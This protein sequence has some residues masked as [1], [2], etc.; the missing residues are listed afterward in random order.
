MPA[1]SATPTTP[2]SSLSAPVT[3]TSLRAAPA[4]RAAAPVT[5]PSSAP[6]FDGSVAVANAPPAPSSRSIDM[7]AWRA[8][9]QVIRAENVPLAAVLEHASPIHCNPERLV[10]GYEP[11]SF[12]AVQAT[13]SAAVE[14]LTRHV[15]AHFGAP[16][17]VA[18]DIT[19]GPKSTPSVASLDNEER[20]KKLEQAKRAV[21]EHPLVRAAVEVLGAELADVRLPE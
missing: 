1:P 11:G 13:E 15:R 5:A 20:R 17:A 21:A 7:T 14:R 4:L 19:A 10:L 18:F 16:T 3:T 2:T 9:L 8:I 6:R 12:L